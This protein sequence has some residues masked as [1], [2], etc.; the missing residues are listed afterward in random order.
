MRGEVSL[1]A[2]DRADDLRDPG[3]QARALGQDPLG[4]VP[5]A[6]PDEGVGQVGQAGGDRALLSD[7]A[8]D[9]QRLLE[10]LARAR[11]SAIS[12]QVRAP[13]VC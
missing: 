4:G 6:E 8:L 5:P 2:P 11:P 12:R 9:R 1:I 13:K 10:Q 7:L 3:R